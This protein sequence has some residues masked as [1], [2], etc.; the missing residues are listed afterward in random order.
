MSRSPDGA[1][2]GCVLIQPLKIAWEWGVLSRGFGG[3][4]NS[5]LQGHFKKEDPVLIIFKFIQRRLKDKTPKY[6]K[7]QKNK[8]KNPHN[9]QAIKKKKCLRKTKD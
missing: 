3:L 6:F 2:E 8:R 1:Q 7:K 4:W 9:K 5:I